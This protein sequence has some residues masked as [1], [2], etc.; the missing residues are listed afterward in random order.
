MSREVVLGERR[1]QS[2]SWRTIGDDICENGEFDQRCG[3]VERGPESGKRG[4]ASGVC[5][6]RSKGGYFFPAAESAA[7]ESAE[8]AAEPTES[9]AADD[10]AVLALIRAGARRRMVTPTTSDETGGEVRRAAAA[11]PTAAEPAEPAAEPTESAAFSSSAASSYLQ[12]RR[13]VGTLLLKRVYLNEGPKVP[14]SA[15]WASGNNYGTMPN[16]DTSLVEDMSMDTNYGGFSGYQQWASF[17]VD[18]SRWNTEKVTDMSYMFYSASAFNQDIGS[19]NT[20]QVTT[21]QAMFV[22]LLRSTKPLGIGTQRK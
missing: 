1:R 5:R 16:W 22:P 6:A 21:M 2:R 7:A 11:E 17:N 19:W 9:A 13:R 20:A 14:A 10:V 12:Y 8:P 3:G 15:R 4:F 18:I